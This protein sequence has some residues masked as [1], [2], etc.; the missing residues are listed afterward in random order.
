LPR[1][2]AGAPG[3]P[4][5]RDADADA[6]PD[7]GDGGTGDAGTS[8][9]AG[10]A[11]TSGG[12]G[13]DDPDAGPGAGD[14]DGADGPAA[15]D[16]ADEEEAFGPEPL[17]VYDRA[18]NGE[19]EDAYPD[20]ERVVE[21][22][23]TYCFD[24]L[25]ATGLQVVG[26]EEIQVVYGYRVNLV[27][28]PAGYDAT[29][30]DRGGDA[31]AD[32]DLDDATTRLIPDEP[33]DGLILLAVREQPGEAAEVLIEGPQ[34]AKWSTATVKESEHN[35]AGVAPFS[36][37][38]ISGWVWEDADKDGIQLED[39]SDV[40]YPGMVV[41]LERRSTS[42]ADAVAD[43]WHSRT[44][45]GVKGSHLDLSG[46]PLEKA[47]RTIE[48]FDL[49]PAEGP[50]GPTDPDEPNKPEEPGGPDGPADPEPGPDGPDAPDAEGDEPGFPDA[51]AAED[52]RLVV[53]EPLLAMVRARL[54]AEGS[55]GGK[56]DAD[57]SDKNDADDDPEEV[58]DPNERVEFDGILSEGTW[59][60]AGQTVTDEDGCY[61]FVVPVVDAQ[62]KPY[63]Y[64]LR[65]DKP[66]G[67]EY[68]PLNAGDS[69]ALDNEWAHL[70]LVG[71]RVP[72]HEGIT[73]VLAPLGR[74]ASGPNAYGLTYATFAPASWARHEDG[75]GNPVDLGLHTPIDPEDPD[76]PPSPDDPRNPLTPDRLPRDP[77][78]PVLLGLPQTGDDVSWIYL[79]LTAAGVSVALIFL[80]LLFGR[81]REEEEA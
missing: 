53:D 79:V 63:Q 11:G 80:A 65:M 59:E 72:E 33:V 68:V 51:A 71:Q 35:D 60:K 15:G 14:G 32:S 18:F 56:D 44:T 3:G 12:T 2:A 10:D 6:G 23:G 40:K 8:G 34:G 62:G 45:D 22:D 64:R 43:G 9:G 5:T 50:D 66:D 29:P 76:N 24:D 42:L 74:K 49:G 47:P 37:A 67:T 21:A 41:T 58:I 19:G 27:E 13:D 17:W 70:N 73:D 4:T 75:T 81:R 52:G 16:G 48:W 46:E 20:R 1:K 54:A 78:H 69:D 77:K 57:A 28:L 61:R 36:S 31:T 39:L 25:P 55:A 26:G 7:A 30:R 38:L